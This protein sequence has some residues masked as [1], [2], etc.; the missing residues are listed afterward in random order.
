M[1]PEQWMTCRDVRDELDRLL[2]PRNELE[3]R[4]AGF[5]CQKG[6][7]WQTLSAYPGPRSA[8]GIRNPRLP[9]AWRWNQI[10]DFSSGW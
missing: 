5:H 6:T 8:A 1:R 7:T 4:S 2:R 10:H 9:Q 3:R